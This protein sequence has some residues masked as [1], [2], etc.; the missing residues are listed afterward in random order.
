MDIGKSVG[1]VFDDKDWLPKVLIGGVVS[2]IPIVDLAALG[3]AVRVLQRVARGDEHPLPEWSDFGDYFVKG[4][5]LTI[6]TMIYAAPVIVLNI[7]TTIA[8]VT[9]SDWHLASEVA[10]VAIG[11]LACLQVVLGLAV[12]L[13]T[14]AAMANYAASGDF[15]AFFRFG[16]IWDLIARN[17]G[18]YTLI[19]VASIVVS[20][21]A[22]IVGLV[23]CLVGAVFT[24]FVA[25]LIY[26]HLLGQ[27]LGQ[28]GRTVVAPA[29]G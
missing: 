17:A 8:S 13:W 18:D 6:A 5:L 20:V 24:S 25:T 15:G 27:L 19:L 9:P 28:S 14:P 2:A 16:E 4:L 22:G 29:A 23:L 3:Y 12:A 10:P 1:F 26:A 11:V 21:V 7:V